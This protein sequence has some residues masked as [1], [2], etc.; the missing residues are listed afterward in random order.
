MQQ[1]RA[2]AAHACGPMRGVMVDRTARTAVYGLPEVAGVGRPRSK[3]LRLASPTRSAGAISRSRRGVRDRRSRRSAQADLLRRR[4]FATGCAL[5]R[6]NR[7]RSGQSAT[8]SGT[9][10]SVESFRSMA[11]NTPTY[12]YAYHDAAVDGLTRLSRHM[13]L[14]DGGAPGGLRWR[15]LFLHRESSRASGCVYG[16]RCPR[17]SSIREYIPNR[18]ADAEKRDLLRPLLTFHRVLSN[19]FTI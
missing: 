3:W 15:K 14:S 17:R 1:G 2:A 7:G 8:S 19:P 5:F 6:R 12:G 4:S 18:S 10:G 9:G 16:R 11:L 13:G